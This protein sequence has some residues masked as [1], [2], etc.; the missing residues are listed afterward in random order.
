MRRASSGFTRVGWRLAALGVLGFVL[1]VHGSRPA[2]AV[3]VIA[4][5]VRIDRASTPV[6]SVVGQT[7]IDIIPLGSAM[8]TLAQ[9]PIVL[10]I[11]GETGDT[12]TVS[13]T[14]DTTGVARYS[15]TPQFPGLINFK[16]FNDVNHNGV[17]DA[18]E[19][20]TT[21]STIVVL[22]L[23]NLKSS[24]IG[25]GQVDFRGMFPSATAPVLGTFSV[26]LKTSSVGTPSGKF[27]FSIPDR[28]VSG[29]STHIDS[30]VG[31]NYMPTVSGA[32]VEGTVRVGSSTRWFE[33][34]AVDGGPT[35]TGDQFHLSLYNGTDQPA[36]FGG[37]NLIPRNG[38]RNNL[39]YQLGTKRNWDELFVWP[40]NVDYGTVHPQ[41]YYPKSIYFM[42]TWTS[43]LSA[44]FDT[45]HLDVSYF[46][47]FPTTPEFSIQ[48]GQYYSLT[49]TFSSRRSCTHH[50]YLHVSSLG[51]TGGG[52]NIPF[53]VVSKF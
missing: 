43:P 34:T 19:A 51:L 22:P 44:Q 14:S 3:P 20:F 12:Q 11:S 27:S 1:S 4:S 25:S 28:Q 52:L 24:L 21:D 53:S 41:Q 2:D 31:F 29:A 36:F 30:M 16:A 10:Q 17:L 15:F 49:S 46:N 6:S 32:Y 7:D 39:T 33:F 37:G 13:L 48:G 40:R 26:N 5:Y 8:Q 45:S 9:V 35:G 50:G 42:N 23:N 18:G 47:F 38:L